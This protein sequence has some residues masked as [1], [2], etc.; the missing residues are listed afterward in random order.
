VLAPALLHWAL[1]GVAVDVAAHRVTR[2]GVELRIT[3][4]EFRVLARLVRQA[5]RVVTHR[6]LLA[7]V[8]GPEHVDDTQYLRLYLGQLRAKKIR[9]NQPRAGRFPWRYGCAHAAPASRQCACS[10]VRVA[11]PWAERPLPA[12]V[13]ACWAGGHRKLA[14]CCARVAADQAARAL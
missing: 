4:T 12:R 10:G 6:Q 2:D 5:G 3:P 7:D 13:W 14:G 8:W 1:D 11:A 9:T